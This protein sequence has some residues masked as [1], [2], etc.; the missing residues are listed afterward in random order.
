MVESVSIDK[1]RA[2]AVLRFGNSAASRELFQDIADGIRRHVPVG[3]QVHA[4]EVEQRKGA[5]DL[6]RVTDWEPFEISIVS[7]PADPTVGVGRDARQ[8][9]E[10]M[11]PKTNTAPTGASTQGEED[12]VTAVLELGRVC[13][14]DALAAEI[15][16]AGGGPEEMQAR[17]LEHMNA[18][19]NQP[20]RDGGSI[21][22]TEREAGRFSFMALIRHLAAPTAESA[23]AAAFE[24]EC[25]RA[26]A[27]R[28]GRE[29]QGAFIPPDVL[30]SRNFG[31]ALNTRPPPRAPSW[32]QPICWPGTS[33]TFC[34]TACRSCRRARPCFRVW[35]GTWQSRALRAAQLP[36]GCPRAVRSRTRA[37]RPTL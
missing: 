2:R 12:R 5:A 16:R 21:G 32:W 6:V 22:L 9:G 20:L 11:P 28:T 29:P 3:Y 10:P 7:V 8:A 27:R 13:K 36:N 30:L 19:G 33:S 26:F 1:G 37:P 35:S 31:G 34:G 17:I 24:L 23:E 15:L 25:S 18:N 4:I 14:H